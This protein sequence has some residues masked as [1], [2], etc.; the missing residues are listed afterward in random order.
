MTA[1]DLGTLPRARWL[2]LAAAVESQV[3]HPVA[4]AVVAER[5]RMCGTLPELHADAVRV[6]PGR[7]A[8][9]QVSGMRVLVGS[10]RLMAEH[11]VAVPEV[12]GRAAAAD[13]V[14]LVYVA[15]GG[16]VEGALWLH[17]PLRPDAAEAL[18]ALAAM[19]LRMHLFSGDTPDVVEAVAA[20]VGIDHAQ[21]GMLPEDKLQAV[22]RLQAQGAVVAMVGDGV[23]D[24]PALAAADVGIALGTGSDLALETAGVLLLRPSLGGV[25]DTVRIAR[26]AYRT[27]RQNLAI[28]VG[29]NLCAI[30]LALLGWVI[31]LLAAVSMSLSSLLV[32][33]N[34]LRLR[35]SA[36]PVSPAVP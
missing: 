35:V 26:R 29:Y 5:E 34:A 31:P 6:L 28:S 1:W 3:V 20:R 23:N 8:E 21:G 33:L 11:G 14:S 30:P 18:D 25:L 2:D 7:G 13:P 9:G 12:P 16:A 10:G 32:V 4:R 15:A 22:A 19:G 36:R 24:G 17:D 27:I